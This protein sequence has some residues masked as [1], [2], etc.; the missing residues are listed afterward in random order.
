MKAAKVQ[1]VIVVLCS[2]I[3]EI[4]RI[5]ESGIIQ[6]ECDGHKY[7][8]KRTTEL[9]D[10]DVY[11]ILYRTIIYSLYKK[12]IPFLV[13][14]IPTVHLVRFLVTSRKLRKTVLF[15][16][17]S[18]QGEQSNISIDYLTKVLAVI[19]CM[20]IICGTPS[21]I[22]PIVRQFVPSD[23]DCTSAFHYFFHI[24]DLLSLLNSSLNFFVYYVNIPAFRKCLK[25][26]LKKCCI[27]R[28]KARDL[29]TVYTV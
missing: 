7:Y 4:P 19:A 16:G 23:T 13:I 5:F 8:V 11:D 14:F 1:L 27:R 18:N 29:Y 20:Y 3:L 28:K 12:Y 2:I 25:D 17:I 9:V 26:I 15:N 22:Y 10:N 6:R 21:A 24:A